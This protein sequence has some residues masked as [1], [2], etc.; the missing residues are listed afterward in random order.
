VIEEVERKVRQR[1]WGDAPTT[2]WLDDR[3]SALEEGRVTPFLVADALLA[4]SA[5]LLTRA[6]ASGARREGV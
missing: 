1:L 2:A 4:Q 5:D 6:P 3:L